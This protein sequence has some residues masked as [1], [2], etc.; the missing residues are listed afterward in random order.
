MLDSG[1]PAGPAN[2]I[3]EV[4]QHA[5]TQHRDMVIKLD[6]YRGIGATV[7]F[8]RT[9]PAMRTRPALFTADTRA[10]LEEGGYSESEI[11]AMIANNVVVSERTT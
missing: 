6:G 11:E 1:V 2:G 10:I 9:P 3:G 8:S 4:L 5:H 7:K